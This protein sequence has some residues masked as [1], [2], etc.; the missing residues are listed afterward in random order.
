MLPEQKA[1]IYAWVDGVIAAGFRA[2]MY[3][4]G[5][6]AADDGNVV[7][8]KDIRDTQATARPTRHR[9]LGHER[10]LPARARDALFHSIRRAPPKA[11]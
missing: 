7:T 4:S 1:Y 5:I 11:A 9:L 6:P 8:A 10:R 2:G 3:C